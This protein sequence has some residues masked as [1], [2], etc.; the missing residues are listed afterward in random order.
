[1]LKKYRRQFVALN[2]LLVGI[3]LVSALIAVTVYTYRDYTDELKRTM[4]QVLEPLEA[5]PPESSDEIPKIGSKTETNES[6]STDLAE[7]E[8]GNAED[9]T[10]ADKKRPE[11]RSDIGIKKEPSKRRSLGDTKIITVKYFSD[12]NEYSIRSY[13]LSISEERIQQAARFA[14]SQEESFGRLPG[15]RLY[16]Y[17]EL[18]SDG[19]CVALTHISYLNGSM[20]KLMSILLI[21]LILAMVLFY[22]LSHYISKIAVRPLEKAMSLEKQFVADI[23]HELKTPLTVILANNSIL[24][25]NEDSPVSEQINWI[26]STD[27]AARNMMNMVENMLTLSA[28]ESVDRTVVTEKTNLS[29]IVT[30]AALQMESVAFEKGITPTTDIDENITIQ[31]NR[32]Y[33]ENI[34]RSLIDNALKYEPTGGKIAISLTRQKRNAVFSVHNYGSTI[35]KEDLPHVFERFYR[36]SVARGEHKGHGLGLA[37]VK[38]SVEA[39][40]GK[41]DASSSDTEGTVFTVTFPA[42]Q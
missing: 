1:M 40:N 20:A 39:M 18:H 33:L 41:I 27:N 28:L 14:A 4:K 17:R 9:T 12:T 30:K 7:S 31:G 23:S 24:K 16:Y 38:Q 22:I 32:E 19:Y 11:G 42:V 34:C 15:Y 25:E 26:D 36:S 10:P 6:E 21:I 5:I 37:I 13:D 3:I 8:S 35:P 2:M 29:S